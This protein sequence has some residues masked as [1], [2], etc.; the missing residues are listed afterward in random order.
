VH[1][2]AK[3]AAGRGRAAEALVQALAT[4]PPNRLSHPS[5]PPLTPSSP[6]R[7][8]EVNVFTSNFNDLKVAQSKFAGSIA[9]LDDVGAAAG[10]ASTAVVVPHLSRHSHSSPPSALPPPSFAQ[11]RRPSSP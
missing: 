10:G 5:S 11:A 3:A 9:A 8:Q 2:L 7:A 1:A 6:T 4:R